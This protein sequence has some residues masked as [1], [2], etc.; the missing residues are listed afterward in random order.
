M[1]NRDGKTRPRFRNAFPVWLAEPTRENVSKKVG[2]PLSD[3]FPHGLTQSFAN[4]SGSKQS[5]A[6]QNLEAKAKGVPKSAAF[7][8][9]GASVPTVAWVTRLQF[10]H[11]TCSVNFPVRSVT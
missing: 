2:D 4:V 6:L 7:V 8:T 1:W 9:D 3:Q 11:C 10:G 5:Q